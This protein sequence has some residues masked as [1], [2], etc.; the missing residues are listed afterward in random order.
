MNESIFSDQIEETPALAAPKA[1]Q[2]IVYGGLTV[3]TLDAIAASIHAGIR[4]T[5]PD[6]V[7]QYVAS[8]LLGREAAYSG[9]IATILMGLLMHYSIAFAVVTVFYLI[10][11]R[12]PELL[13]HVFIVG[14]IYGII[15]YFMMAYVFVPLTLIPPRPFNLTNTIIGI[16]IHIFCIGLPTALWARYS[17]RR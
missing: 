1:F 10:S 2:T 15:V 9:G 3:G 8:A 7:W 12:V 4:G 11:S 5:T 16:L 13:R 6:L 17:A 14:P